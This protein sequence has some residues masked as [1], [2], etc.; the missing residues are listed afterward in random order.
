MSLFT[1]E[2]DKRAFQIKIIT[3]LFDKTVEESIW[4]FFKFCLSLKLVFISHDLFARICVFS[5]FYFGLLSCV[6]HNGSLSCQYFAC[7]HSP[8]EVFWLVKFLF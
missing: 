3:Q 4:T 6:T 2:N 8:L 1:V 5:L 7:T